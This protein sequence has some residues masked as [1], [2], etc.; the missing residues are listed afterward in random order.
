MADIDDILSG[1]GEPAPETT[2][3]EPVTTE[4]PSTETEKPEGEGTKPVGMVPH[5]ALHA[6]KQKV[7]RYTEEVAEF[8]KSNEALQRQLTE[9][10][11]R[12]PVPKAEQPPPTDWF[13]NPD[14]AFKQRTQ[15]FIDPVVGQLQSLQTKL[16]RMEAASIFGD[17]FGE[18]MSVVTEGNAKRDPEIMALQAMMDASPEPY[19]VAKQWFEKRS[20][21]PEAERE[22][23]RAEIR[24]EF[25]QQPQTPSV[26]VLPSNLAGARNVGTRTGPA[27]A[28]PTPIADIFRR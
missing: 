17:K 2:T 7:K 3:N 18:F 13:E 26:P 23:L 28:G 25:E 8:R 16:A 15:Q 24:A 19:V 22:R 27:W 12:V 21:D 14:E 11:Q 6:E 5:E 1:E 10:M 4:A 9:L 20:F